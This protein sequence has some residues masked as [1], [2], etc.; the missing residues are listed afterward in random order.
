MLNF[1]RLSTSRSNNNPPSE[2]IEPPENEPVIWWRPRGENESVFGVQFVIGK[3]SLICLRKPH[4]IWVS[5]EF[6][7]FICEICGILGFGLTLKF[8]Q[9]TKGGSSCEKHQHLALEDICKILTQKNI[10][11]L[12]FITLLYGFAFVQMESIF[13]LFAATVYHLNQT[14]IGWIFVYLGVLIA[15]SQGALVGKLS[16][17]FG[18]TTLL[19]FGALLLVFSFFLISCTKNVWVMITL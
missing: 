12:I 16:S 13:S 9:E 18:N 8:L 4:Y 3:S 1:K 2:V 14:Q 17:R 11:L 7:F 15:V 10:G 5:R 19:L 6:P